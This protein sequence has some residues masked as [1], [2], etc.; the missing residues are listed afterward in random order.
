M[1]HN[2]A[3]HNSL[4]CSP[5]EIFPGRTPYNPLDL[6]FK[7]SQKQIEHRMRLRL[8]KLEVLIDDIIVHQQIYSYNDKVEDT[9][10]FD[11][12]IPRKDEV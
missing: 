8:F 11:S 4:K 1:S 3:Y 10:I 6:L 9:D 7:N 12:N 2:T 5:T